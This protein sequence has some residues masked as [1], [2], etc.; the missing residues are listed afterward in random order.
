MNV[1]MGTEEAGE[2]DTVRQGR[3]RDS[4]SWRRECGKAKREE[5]RQRK[6]TEGRTETDTKE[7]NWVKREERQDHTPP[8][9]PHKHTENNSKRARG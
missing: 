6:D 2:G 5:E 3:H 8:S 1:D 9:P 4:D 7:E